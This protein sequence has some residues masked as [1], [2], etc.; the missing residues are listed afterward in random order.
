MSNHWDLYCRTCKV[1]GSVAR[2]N[3]G[4]E[5]GLLT[6]IAALPEIANLKAALKEVDYVFSIPGAAV[7]SRLSGF[8]AEHGTHDVVPISEY[9]YTY[10]QC[11]DRYY[12]PT[13]KHAEQCELDK[14]HPGEHGPKVTR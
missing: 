13:C 2:W 5:H 12:C 11:E 3:H 9:G 8:A 6:V 4:P 10:D 14:D 7:Y 1:K